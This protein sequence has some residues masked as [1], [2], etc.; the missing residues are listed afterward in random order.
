MDSYTSFCPTAENWAPCQLLMSPPNL[1]ISILREMLM[2]FV[3]NLS[4]TW[5]YCLIDIYLPVNHPLACHLFSDNKFSIMH[6]AAMSEKLEKKKKETTNMSRDDNEQACVCD[7][8]RDVPQQ[9]PLT[10]YKLVLSLAHLMAVLCYC[11]F[12]QRCRMAGGRDP[13]FG[14]AEKG[15]CLL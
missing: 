14:G 6:R 2:R 15:L 7:W 9:A 1:I 10:L 3:W 11:M 5:L 8:E 4:K 12:H 13:A